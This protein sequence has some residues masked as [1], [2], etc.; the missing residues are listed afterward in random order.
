MLIGVGF[1]M[2]TSASMP[3][4]E[5]LFDNPYHITIR[6]SMFLAMSFCAILD[7][8][9]VCPWTWWKRSNPYLLLMGI[10]AVE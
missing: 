4:A 8:L 3:T 9:H 5:R 2:V 1:V 10:G 7:R 6:H